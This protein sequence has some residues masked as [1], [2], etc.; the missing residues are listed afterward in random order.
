ME[1]TTLQTTPRPGRSALGA[2][3]GLV[4]GPAAGLLLALAL[5]AP[6]AHADIVHLKDGRTIEG[7]IVDRG[8]RQLTV[9]TDFGNIKVDLSKVDRIEEKLTPEQE[10]AGKRASVADDDAAGLFD[11]AIW[12]RDQELKR[13]MRELLLE[14]VAA[15]GQHALANEM[16]GNVKVDGRWLPPDQVDAYLAEVAEEKQAQGLVLYEGKWITEADAMEKQGFLMV[17]GA[18]VPRRDAETAEAVEAFYDAAG[19][20]LEAMQ[21]EFITLYSSLAESHAETLVFDLDAVV[22]DFYSKLELTDVLREQVVEVDIP[23]WLMPDRPSVQ[24]FIETGFIDRYRPVSRIKEQYLLASNFGLHWPRPCIVAVA[25]GTQLKNNDDAM[26]AVTGLVSHQ[27]GHLLV[28][29][30]KKRRSPGWL[31]AGLAAYYEGVCNYHTSLSITSFKRDE[32]GFAVEAWIDDWENFPQWRDNLLDE[33]FHAQLQPLRQLLRQDLESFDSRQL[34]QLWSFTRFLIERH[35]T[36]L[37]DYLKLYDE[38]PAMHIKEDVAVHEDTW[39]RAFAGS[40]DELERE[41]RN[42]AL[43]Q[44]RRFPSEELQR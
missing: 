9:K 14:V 16:L 33:S 6:T 23:V 35:G 5:L 38:E 12:A 3:R 44:S 17:D 28:Q 19:L 43:G 27:L 30:L 34:G 42:W 10:L 1:I 37:A 31:R 36:E 13:P 29:R 11:L 40:V 18:W 2:A 22:R 21:G 8:D 26:S 25:R 4:R 39:K 24:A 7:Q 15:D 32:D 20:P 41:W